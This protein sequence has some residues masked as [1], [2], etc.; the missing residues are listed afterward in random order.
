MTFRE[1]TS[2]VI[3]ALLCSVAFSAPAIAQDAGDGTEVTDPINTDGIGDGQELGGDEGTVDPTVQNDGDGTVEPGV[4]YGPEDCIDCNSAPTVMN[5]DGG[6]RP[7]G[8]N[9]RGDVDQPAVV[10]ERSESGDSD[11]ICDITKMG[12]AAKVCP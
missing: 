5:M 6:G 10:V 1:K 4:P 9:F 7:V 8:E 12:N 3:L 2:G 11:D